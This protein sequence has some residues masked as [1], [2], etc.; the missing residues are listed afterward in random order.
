MY[1]TKTCYGANS[2]IDILYFLSNSII[3]PHI[4]R[5]YFSCK[6]DIDN[7]EERLF[8]VLKENNYKCKKDYFA[9]GNVYKRIRFVISIVTDKTISILYGRRKL[10]KFYPNI[11]IT[12]YRPDLDTYRLV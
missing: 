6:S 9:Q 7:L 12:I 2:Y 10:S 3:H 11:G 5:M 8:S 4:D 1:N